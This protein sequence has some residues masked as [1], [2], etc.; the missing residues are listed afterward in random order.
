[1]PLEKVPFKRYNL[2]PTKGDYVQVRLKPEER[3]MLDTWK[4]AIHQPKDSTAFK[5]LLKF[6]KFT[7]KYTLF[8]HMVADNVRKNIQTGLGEY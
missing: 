2:E 3:E 5:Q 4:A 7:D 8:G 1:M 6:V